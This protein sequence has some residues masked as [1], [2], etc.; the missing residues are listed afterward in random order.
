M[1]GSSM[2]TSP[3]PSALQTLA[4][5]GAQTSRSALLELLLPPFMPLR[6]T[7]ARTTSPTATSRATRRR[8]SESCGPVD[9]AGREGLEL[10]VGGTRHG[11]DAAGLTGDG[12]LEE[13]AGQ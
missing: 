10:A 6:M 3:A 9:I 11:D 5:S 4:S 2:S 1:P 7:T 13:V 8:T 12:R